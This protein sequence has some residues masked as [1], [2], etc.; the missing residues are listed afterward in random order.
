M[1]IVYP[2]GTGST[3]N[4]NELRYSLRSLKHMEHDRVFIVGECPDWAVNVCHIPAEDPYEDQ[5]QLNVQHKL[6]TLLSTD[7]SDDFILMNDDFFILRDMKPQ[8]EYRGPLADTVS[9]N[10]ASG[11][12]HDAIKNA[13]A[14][15]P[16][17]LD[18][19]L[20]TPFVYNKDKLRQ[21]LD[22][23][24][25]KNIVLRSVY[26]NMHE[27]GGFHAT[28][29]KIYGA[30]QFLSYWN[31]MGFE[32]IDCIS[33]SDSLGLSIDFREWIANYYPGPGVYEL[34]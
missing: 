10:Y 1:D 26:G 27:V 22:A 20:H 18:Y 9:K 28:D 4:N 2:L 14:M 8:Y 3:W 30:D 12:Y 16:D 31:V 13:H 34:S 33:I 24:Q 32:G 29:V 19:S 25:D 21:A 11:S 6:R 17:G 23:V 15:Y 5:P 7:V